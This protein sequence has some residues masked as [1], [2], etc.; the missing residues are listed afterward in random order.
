MEPAVN[1]KVPLLQLCSVHLSPNEFI[2]P[3]QL[4][5]SY[6]GIQLN[7]NYRYMSACISDTVCYIWSRQSKE[8]ED[9][10]LQNIAQTKILKKVIILL[11]EDKPLTSLADITQQ[12]Y[13]V[14]IQYYPPPESCGI[15]DIH[16][17]AELIAAIFM[18]RVIEKQSSL[19]R[20]YRDTLAS[21]LEWHMK[22]FF[23]LKPILHL[24]ASTSW[25][26]LND[27][28]GEPTI[29]LSPGGRLIKRV[30]QSNVHRS[31][32]PWNSK[33]PYQDLSPI[34]MLNMEC[35]DLCRSYWLGLNKNAQHEKLIDQNFLENPQMGLL[36]DEEV[37][38]DIKFELVGEKLAYDIAR[39]IQYLS[40][41]NCAAL[42]L[43][44]SDTENH[45][46]RFQELLK[47]LMVGLKIKHNKREEILDKWNW[48]MKKEG[49]DINKDLLAYAVIQFFNQDLDQGADENKLFQLLILMRQRMNVHP[50][51]VIRVAL[52]D[53][54]LKF[55]NNHPSRVMSYQFLENS[56]FK[57]SVTHF[58]SFTQE[59]KKNNEYPS[60]QLE[61]KNVMSASLKNLDVWSSSITFELSLQ[62]AKKK[63]NE[64]KYLL[65]Q[66]VCKPLQKLGFSVKII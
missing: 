66:K 34:K 44:K 49:A 28:V 37:A 46:L 7:A 42:T 9:V 14:E 40:V 8:K 51:S 32:L 41:I 61:M 4:I 15:R 25:P 38:R 45:A 65:E 30:S 17:R 33:H 20:C 53:I 58:A 63:I 59:D 36:V 13:N 11:R 5:Q 57:Y 23:K 2:S 50:M 22:E 21:N 52:K 64:S 55:E 29:K 12:K 3:S 54:N 26:L 19:I 31:I 47:H 56:E 6:L 18:Q 1:N 48:H 10:S 27:D 35:L 24:K 16:C 62:S 60:F 43:E 39:G